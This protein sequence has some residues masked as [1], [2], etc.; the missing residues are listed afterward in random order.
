MNNIALV[1]GANKGIGKEICRQL[2][3]R[4]LTVILTARDETKAKKAL[5]E[6]KG[7]IVF[8][9]LDVTNL[10][11]ISQLA[12]FIEK[13]YGM[14]DI[15]I[16]NAGISIGAKGIE[17]VDISEIRTIFETN[18]FGPLQLNKAM[19]PLLKKSNDARII[20]ISSSMGAL[21]NLTGGYAGYRLSKAGLN[22]Q[23]LL[24]ANE[25]GNT[26]VKVFSMCPGWVRTDMGGSSASLSVEQGA[27][28]AV[29]LST[30]NN[31]VSGKF[32][33]NR[34]IIAW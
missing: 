12:T 9:L 28:T 4:N 22:A 2:A 25:L 27:D 34:K 10:G 5:S 16:N 24:L 31:L 21:I 23:T 17:H 7:N 29:W 8:H 30:E 14:L 1:T 32:Y 19:L 6:I 13:Q 33:K 11:S 26:T 15:L 18:F 20:N 3:E